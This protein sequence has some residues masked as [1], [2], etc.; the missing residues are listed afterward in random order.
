ML[1]WQ[2]ASKVRGHDPSYHPEKH[3]GDHW[4]FIDFSVTVLTLVLVPLGYLWGV[5]FCACEI[6]VKLKIS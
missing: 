5:E 4:K 3:L 6:N 1:A 2:K